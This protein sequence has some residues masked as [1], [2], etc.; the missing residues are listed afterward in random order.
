MGGAVAR[1]VASRPKKK[2]GEIGG[3]SSADCLFE[4]VI[5]RCELFDDRAHDGVL[6]LHLSDGL[7]QFFEVLRAQA[8]PP[9]L[10]L[11]ES[12]GVRLRFFLRL[13][14][15]GAGLSDGGPSDDD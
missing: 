6:L 9:I 2:G 8:D 10:L 13:C 3:I 4:L 11:S 12:D 7:L 15:R 14:C 5:F 1:S